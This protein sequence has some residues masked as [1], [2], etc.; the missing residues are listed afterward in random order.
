MKKGI[1][2]VIITCIIAISMV[3]ASC[4]SATTT[5]TKTPT[6]TTV[7]PTSTTTMTTSAPVTSTTSVTS[8]VISTTAVTT[9]ATGNWWDS[10]GKPSYGSS[11]T[12]RYAADPTS[13]DNFNNE[14]LVTVMEA[15]QSRLFTDQWTMNPTQWNYALVSWRPDSVN[16]GDLATTWDFPDPSTFE[17]HLRQGVY[18]QNIA[19]ANGRQFV[20]SDVVYNYDRLYA[21][22]GF[23]GSPSQLTNAAYKKLISVT[24][25]DNFTVV[26]K[27]S[28]PNPTFIL[29]TMEAPLGAAVD[30]ECPEAIQQFGTPMS[31]WH[32]AIG[33]GP[34]IL[35]DF[36]DNSSATFARNTTYFGH[37]ERYPQN[38]LPYVDTLKILIIPDASTSLS[39]LRTGKIDAIGNIA[40]SDAQSLDK[41]NP[42]LVKIGVPA[43]YSNSIDPKGGVA[44]FTDI[45]VRQAM[46]QSINLPAIA[47]DYYLGTCSPAPSTM[48]SN[49]MGMGWGYPYNTWPAALQA[50]Y[51]YN[52]TNAKALLAAAG[53]PNG[54]NTDV[55]ADGGGDMGL[56]QIV[57]SDFAA[58]GINMT[59]RIMP[60]AQ[61]AT[62]VTTNHGQDQLSM[63]G[64]GYLGMCFDVDRQMQRFLTG[65]NW[66]NFSDPT[67]D[68]LYAQSLAA[69]SVTAYQ[70]IFNQ[71]NQY[72]AQN[73]C[74]ISLVTPENYYY[75]QPWLKGF[76]AQ[77][78][79]VVGNSGPRLIGFYCARYWIDQSQK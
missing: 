16:A 73:N 15:Y 19:P 21:L 38:K 79:S 23:P 30:V 58:I 70:S 35:T 55:V 49:N 24:A 45:R 2:G 52:P 36:V 20:A 63:R 54:F 10:L 53:F 46:Q 12:V 40:V 56:L 33:T 59:L 9:T 62:F 6:S 43:T 65:A 28:I 1:I 4:S 22:A 3:L 60:T 27:W 44:P 29:S 51:A 7:P 5:T 11:I 42:N 78:D 26:F 66:S 37:D 75:N 25:T 67:C 50:Q 77:D 64:T 14:G 68:S 72:I 69:T 41:T 74:M 8:T 57:Q 71:M 17:V 39:A 34:F 13:W 76:M 32:N 18:W 31:S 61:Y 48:T 47:K